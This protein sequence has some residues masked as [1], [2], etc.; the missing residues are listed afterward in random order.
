MSASEKPDPPA[1]GF[2]PPM[3]N[4]GRNTTV[5]RG[6][7]RHALPQ[8]RLQPGDGSLSPSVKPQTELK[9]FPA[10]GDTDIRFEHDLDC[11]NVDGWLL[12]LQRSYPRFSAEEKITLCR[13]GFDL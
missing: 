10:L 3:F 13:F 5:C 8:V 2:S 11:G 12:V 1:L 4:R 6:R 9:E 7:K